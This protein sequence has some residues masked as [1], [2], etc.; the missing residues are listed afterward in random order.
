[1]RRLAAALLT[2]VFTGSS[3]AQQIGQT[4]PKDAQ[5]NYTL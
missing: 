3:N 5:E 4:R 2:L 1:M